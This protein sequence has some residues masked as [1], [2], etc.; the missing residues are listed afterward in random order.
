M[1]HYEN[2][3]TPLPYTTVKVEYGGIPTKSDLL[4]KL[5]GNAVY[6]GTS[7]AAFSSGWRT[8]KAAKTNGKI[9]FKNLD[10]SLQVDFEQKKISGRIEGIADS[11]RPAGKYNREIQVNLFDANVTNENGNISFNST[12]NIQI[13]SYSSNDENYFNYRGTYEGKF[14][15]DNAQ[16]IAGKYSSEVISPIPPIEYIKSVNGGFVAAKQ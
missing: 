11:S 6:K 2:S 5:S 16:Q 14:M 8:P 15:G 10:V 3:L 13:G 7:S 1:K 12:A 4:T 9:E